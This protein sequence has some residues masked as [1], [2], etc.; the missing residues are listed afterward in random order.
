MNDFIRHVVA[1]AVPVLGILTCLI[2][3]RAPD[4]SQH[5]NGRRLTDYIEDPKRSGTSA[6]PQGDDRRRDRR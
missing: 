5:N 4:L 2:Y 6:N 3:Q 1:L